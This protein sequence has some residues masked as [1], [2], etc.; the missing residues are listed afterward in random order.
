MNRTKGY[1]IAATILAMIILIFYYIHALEKTTYITQGEIDLSQTDFANDGVIDLNGE[2]EFYWSQLLTPSDFRPQN[3]RDV[4]YLHVPGNWLRDQEGNTYA[5]KGY[6]TYRVTLHHIPDSK[7]FGLKKANIRNASLI[8]V[9]GK[10][11]LQ[12]GKVSKDLEG[13]VAGNN[14]EVIFFE[15]ADSSAEIIIQVANHEYIVGGIAKA[16]TFGKQKELMQQHIQKSTFE[17]ALIL[18]VVMIGLFYLT[19]F[20]TSNNYRKKEPV[21]LPLALS[22]LIFGV[23]NS[24]FSERTITILLP[25]ITLNSTFRFGHFMNGLS[26]I[27]V[28]LV[29]NKVNSSFLSNLIRNI[30]FIFFGIFLLCV[31]VLP[32][33][34]YLTTITFYMLSAIILLFGLWLW[35]F[36]L[37]LKGNLQLGHPIE[38]GTLIVSVFSI[39]LFWF[40]MVIYSLGLKIDLLVSF[41][42][43]AVYSISLAILLI[44]RYTNSYSR[45]EELSIKLI[46]AFS[47]LDQSTK[48]VQRNE[49]AFLQAQ[50]K[51]HFLF[52]AL[53]SIIS[54]CYTN[55]EK[56][57][58]LLTDLSNYLKRSFDI[59]L[60]KEFITIE[61]ELA[62][63]EAYVDIEKARFAHRIQ[64]TYDIDAEVLPLQISPL[65]IEPLVENAIRHGVLKNKN[66]GQMKLTI[67]RRHQALYISVEDNGKGM[68][69]EQIQAIRDGESRSS[70][71][72]QGNGISLMNV[73]TRLRN[74]YDVELDFDITANGTKVYF[75]IPIQGGHEEGDP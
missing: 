14:S 46:E 42:S 30:M 34:V 2:W 31:V 56:A 13:S 44:V 24:I 47:T 43:V 3:E 1:F 72:S 28:L 63:I 17:S 66:G 40:D 11:I 7:Y 64:V 4:Q 55:G 5:N 67:K 20:L 75:T 45:N 39:F 48:E 69:M 74:L 51:P 33:N 73:H 27:M 38:H 16:V 12:D 23:M 52:N 49:L 6:A 68:E 65:I 57:A 36:I 41:L 61:N 54:L 71:F 19:L 53:S 26:V 58:K 59:D 29:V 21:T 37:F 10:L 9:N 32:L 8:Y 70:I 15:L 22:C 62:L 18:I 25:E 35:I 60:K 50:I